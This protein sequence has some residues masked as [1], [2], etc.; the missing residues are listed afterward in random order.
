[1]VRKWA[2]RYKYEHTIAAVNQAIVGR[3]TRTGKKLLFKGASNV[4]WSTASEDSNTY[5]K[6]PRPM[7][8]RLGMHYGAHGLLVPGSPAPEV[9]GRVEEEGVEQTE[10]NRPTRRPQPP[11][12]DAPTSSAQAEREIPGRPSAAA[13]PL[14]PS[15]SG[16]SPKGSLNPRL[17]DRGRSIV[18]G[19]E[20]S[21]TAPIRSVTP[22]SRRA[23]PTLFSEHSSPLTEF[24]N[25]PPFNRSLKSPRVATPPVGGEFTPARRQ[26]LGHR[27]RHSIGS[28]LRPGSCAPDT[29]GK[30]LGE[31]KGQEED[32]RDAHTRHQKSG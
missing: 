3:L 6:I 27:S 11:P 29:G 1:M 18:L 14:A 19:T 2:T 17:S 12:E 32:E 9:P 25:T 28:P 21:V 16:S 7:L 31:A 23:T 30:I 5:E 20:P 4:D 10:Q 13:G 15:S 24:S 26:V 8:A 22:A